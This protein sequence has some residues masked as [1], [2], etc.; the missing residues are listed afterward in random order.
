MPLKLFSCFYNTPE[1]KAGRIRIVAWMPED[2][3][4][5]L[6]LSDHSLCALRVLGKRQVLWEYDF[7]SKEVFY[8]LCVD[9]FSSDRAVLCSSGGDV[10]VIQGRDMHSHSSQLYLVP[11]LVLFLWPSIVCVSV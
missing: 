10:A 7:A 9:P 11:S 8:G 2:P 4:C 6:C 3:D 5:V 1:L